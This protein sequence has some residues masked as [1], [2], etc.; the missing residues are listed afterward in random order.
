MYLSSNYMKIIPSILG[1][2]MSRL[3]LLNQSPLARLLVQLRLRQIHPTRYTFAFR[4]HAVYNLVSAL[5]S[6]HLPA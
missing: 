3:P 6:A 2:N 5:C 1:G 4:S